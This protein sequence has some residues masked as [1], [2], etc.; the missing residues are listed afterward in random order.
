MKKALAGILLAILLFS[1]TACGGS[2]KPYDTMAA[3]VASD[4][5]QEQLGTLT[6]SME[7]S[8]ME[9]DIVAEGDKMVYVY[10]FVTQIDLTD[11]AVE[12]LSNAISAQEDTFKEIC[13]SIQ[14]V[15]DVEKPVVAV[16]YINADGS[17]IF[18]Q[19]FSA[20]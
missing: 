19:E 10:T 5:L 9:V 17:K 20:E 13:T 14:T 16:R 4:E 6:R 1:L 8:G 15:V 12:A 7:S 3:Y 18:E 2:T 11:A